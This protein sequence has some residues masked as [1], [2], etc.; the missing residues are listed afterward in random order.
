MK[1]RSAQRNVYRKGANGAPQNAPRT[2]RQGG[3][4]AGAR[5]GVGHN[6]SLVYLGVCAAAVALC[7]LVS[8]LLLRESGPSGP[9]TPEFGSSAGAWAKNEQGFYFNSAGEVI[10]AA[11]RKGIDVSEHQG[12]MDWQKAKDAGIDFAILR[13]GYGSEWNG[14][15]EYDQDD[16]QWRA[17]Y[18]A[19]TGL[20]IPF[21]VY[22][23][24]YATTEEAARSEADHV[25][26]LLGLVAAPHEGLADYTGNPARLSY[27]VYYDLEDPKIT[28][29][30]PEE[31]AKI[32]A[33][34]FDQLKSHGYTGEQGIYAS[35]NWVRGRFGSPA[36][37]PWRKNLWIAR[38]SAELGYTGEYAMWQSSCTEP[39]VEYGAQSEGIDVDFVMEELTIT[40]FADAKCKG[41]QP[42]FTNDTYTNEIWLPQKG[43]K[44]TLTTDQ[45]SVEEGGQQLYY[46]TSD[47]EVATVDRNGVVKA[48]GE[49]ECVITVSLADGRLSTDCIVRVGRVTVPVFATANLRGELAGM[50][51]VAA[52]KADTPEAILIDAGGSLQG[53]VQASL[54]GGMDVCSAFSACGYDLQVFDASDLAFGADRLR[55]DAGMASSASIAANLLNTWDPTPVLSRATFWSRNGISN[56]MNCIVEEAGR[57]IGFFALCSTGSTTNTTNV[58]AADAAETAAAQVA[59]LQAQGADAILCVVG[60]DTDPTP[61]LDALRGLGVNAVISGYAGA[62]QQSGGMPVLAVGTGAAGVARLDLTFAQSGTVSAAPA[63]VERAEPGEAGNRAKAFA[64]NRFA[65]LTAGDEEVLAKKL[66]DMEW[67]DKVDDSITFGNYV[68]EVYLALY[69]ADRDD[70][71]GEYYNMYPSALTVAAG[72]P[73]YGDAEITRGELLSALPG[74]ARVQLVLTTGQ[75]YAELLANETVSETYLESKKQMEAAD[76]P[77]LLVTDTATLATLS[78]QSY[79]VVRDYGDAFWCVRTAINDATGG[80]AEA[81]ALPKAD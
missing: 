1:K 64:E 75:M 27:P 41:E 44:L 37:D 32:V 77:I 51:D 56:G 8:A 53:T 79:T 6:K 42:G 20:E 5:P 22:H 49:G 31:M 4:R 23:Y 19:C 59:A 78:D 36:F 25:A 9:A 66:F 54:T 39:G 29:V 16:A 63:A 2:P 61:L 14:E 52:L 12:E 46:T 26:R 60:A 15:G 33:A 76:G 11:M 62:V 69:T 17:N 10:P 71:P 21:G 13:C 50:E 18:E 68:A 72:S 81:F 48:R 58:Y 47:K 40:G 70:L 65:E 74:G 7:L 57:K 35:L 38:Y 73:A 80:F 28:G 34:F 45:P 3:P 43:D 67:P 55:S 24:S 30:Y